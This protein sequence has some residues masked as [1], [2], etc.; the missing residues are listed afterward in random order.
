MSSNWG[1]TYAKMTQVSWWA[2]AEESEKIVV[3]GIEDKCE[4]AVLFAE[5]ETGDLL[6]P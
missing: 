4:I 2:M 5:A 3:T 6:P 1:Q